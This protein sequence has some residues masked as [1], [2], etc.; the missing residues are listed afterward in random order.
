[1][2]GY[3]VKKALSDACYFARRLFLSTGKAAWIFG[4]TFLIVVM[5]VIVEVDKEQQ[6][7]ELE[8]QQLGVLTT[9]GSSGSSS[10]SAAA[11]K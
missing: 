6:A 11:A 8:N 7:M 5:P 2:A 1:M 4:T 3:T 9:P 10:Q